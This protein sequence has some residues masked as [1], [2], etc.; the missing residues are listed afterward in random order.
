MLGGGSTPQ[1]SPDGSKIFHVLGTKISIVDAANGNL[2]RYLSHSMDIASFCLSPDGKKIAATDQEDFKIW[3]VETGVAEWTLLLNSYARNIRYSNDGSK[4]LTNNSDNFIKLWDATTHE[5]LWT[6]N[7]TN[8]SAPVFS[9]D[10]SKILLNVDN[11]IQ[12]L[13]SNDGSEIWTKNY[14][15]GVQSMHFN[16]DGSKVAFVEG[17]NIKMI[18]LN[19]GSDI[20][21]KSSPSYAI[22][23][24]QIGDRVASRGSDNGIRV[25]DAN[26]GTLLWKGYHD[27]TIWEIAFSPDGKNIASGSSDKKL[28]VWTREKLLSL[29]NPN[30]SFRYRYTSAMNITWSSLN[31]T[32]VKLEYSIDNG[33]N[34]TAIVEKTPAGNGSYNW[35]I[36]KTPSLQCLIRI[37]DSD[38]LDI[39]DISQESFEIFQPLTLTSPSGSEVWKGG[40]YQNITWLSD[41]VSS[42]SL[43]YSLDN[44][45]S[46]NM[47]AND[48]NA[49]NESYSW[50]VP[51]LNSQQCKI[52]IVD[53]DNPNINDENENVFAIYRDLELT[54][55]TGGEQWEINTLQNISWTS[56]T[57]ENIRIELSTDYGTTWTTIVQSISANTNSYVFV[58]PNVPSKKCIVRIFDVNNSSIIDESDSAFTI[59]NRTLTLLNPNGGENLKSGQ[60]LNVNWISEYVKDVKIE[61]TSDNGGNWTTLANSIPATNKSYSIKIP[62]TTST[63]CKIKIT[64]IENTNI[65]DECDSSFSVYQPVISVTAPEGGEKW[66]AGTTQKITWIS[67]NVEN[68]KIEFTS[69]SG[70]NWLTIISSTNANTWN[71]DFVV[72]SISSQK[73][74]IRI[75]DVSDNEIKDESSDFFTMAN[76]TITVVTP[77]GGENWAN[78]D[79]NEITWTSVD[80]EN[81]KIEYS[82]NNGTDWYAIVN[83]I[84][85][86]T[87]NYFW[88][89]PN[90]VSKTC[91]IK[92]SNVENSQFFDESD[93]PFEISIPVGVDNEIDYT[94]PN[95][96]ALLQCYPNPF[97]PSTVISYDLPSTSFVSLKVFNSLGEEVANLVNEI[98]SPGRYKVEFNGKNLS[99]GIY[100]YLLNTEKF[101]QSKKM[102]MIK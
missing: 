60:T 98:K 2:I 27:G 50:A 13:N 100:F 63:S 73:C 39:N 43:M 28:K 102:I 56:I 86:E 26:D 96:Y 75:S 90:I 36:P 47:I 21:T 7:S 91:K 3:D 48:I 16:S 95:K 72:P 81:L 18:N 55:P 53:S 101:S 66:I 59:F 6:K 77:N 11:S 74:K 68:V 22:A 4:I 30:N 93:A 5:V 10:D 78:G 69:D 15:G 71:Y 83:R 41:S 89:V 57:T 58:V 45:D 82:P 29:N 51:Y 12:L 84:S 87:T 40:T 34:W 31:I 52:K 88:V 61:F 49:Q 70:A 79:T 9:P 44:G 65:S 38:N 32:N 8:L 20:W 80:I 97:N 19:D 54:N 92:I 64:D 1:F 37:S 76:P 25:W 24:N 94:I 14:V 85:T 67:D 35:T 62:S 23:L 42:V 99:S 46:W 17:H 33:T